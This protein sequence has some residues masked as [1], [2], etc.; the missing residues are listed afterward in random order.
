MKSKIFTAAVLLPLAVISGC[1]TTESVWV[2]NGSSQQN[3]NMDMGQCRAQAF[4]VP[5]APLMQVAIV[6]NS[7]MEGKGWQLEDRPIRR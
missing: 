2:K 3:F 4:A 5:G 6:Q 7:C 1:A